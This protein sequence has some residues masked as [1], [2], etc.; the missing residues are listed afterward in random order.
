MATKQFEAFWWV[1][2]SSSWWTGQQSKQLKTDTSPVHQGCCWHYKHT[3]SACHL[4]FLP[5]VEADSH[6]AWK[7]DQQL[8]WEESRTSHTPSD[9][10]G[11]SSQEEEKFPA[12][13]CV[14]R[15]H[16]RR[17]RRITELYHHCFS[18][19][20][21]SIHPPTVSLSYTNIP[22][23]FLWRGRSLLLH[24]AWNS[25]IDHDC[26]NPTLV[27]TWSSE[28]APNLR[29][30]CSAPSTPTLFAFL[31]LSPASNSNYFWVFNPPFFPT[32]LLKTVGVGLL[33][34]VCTRCFHHSA[35]LHPSLQPETP[36]PG[37]G[38]G[39]SVRRHPAGRSILTPSMCDWNSLCCPAASEPSAQPVTRRERPWK[40]TPVT[41][42]PV[43]LSQP[44]SSPH[45]VPDTLKQSQKT[46]LTEICHLCWILVFFSI[47]STFKEHADIL[48]SNLSPFLR[49]PLVLCLT[50][51]QQSL[52]RRPKC[53]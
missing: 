28:P 19:S 45:T 48:G 31:T 5:E 26:M 24:S 21:T 4:Q 51:T 17:G 52:H 27:F 42:E 37:A 22:A 16:E 53:L 38:P 25:S 2:S 7:P 18:L 15:L 20:Q 14:N 40:S 30:R 44:S 39:S 34:S 12:H 6:S 3:A 23:P 33:A 46:P 1:H 41:P 49:F 10:S 9:S 8:T 36:D 32:H 11:C 43:G 29:L 50:E 47:W 35:R 13:Q